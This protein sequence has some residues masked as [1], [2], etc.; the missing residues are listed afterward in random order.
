MHA[1]RC[2]VK[3]LVYVDSLF[4]YDIVSLDVSTGSENGIFSSLRR[5]KHTEYRRI[6]RERSATLPEN[7][8]SM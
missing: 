1:E 6:N 4:V 8:S 3:L 5:A 7:S 2:T